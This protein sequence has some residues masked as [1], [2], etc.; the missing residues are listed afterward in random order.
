MLV[1]GRQK[2]ESIMIGRDVEIKIIDVR[3]NQIRLG[4][5]APKRIPVHRR[6]VYEAIIHKRARKTG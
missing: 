4:I 3:G 5:T 1:L 2:G 6:E